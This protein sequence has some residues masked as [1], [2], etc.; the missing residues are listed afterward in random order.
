MS[1]FGQITKKVTTIDK[2]GNKTSNMYDNDGTLKYTY[3]SYTDESGTKVSEQTL[4]DKKGKVKEII[5]SDN[6]GT[7]SASYDEK[8]FKTDESTTCKNGESVTYSY[9]KNGRVTQRKDKSSNG[10]STVTQYD[11]NGNVTTYKEDM[12]YFSGI[13]RY[14]SGEVNENGEFSPDNNGDILRFADGT[15]VNTNDLV[16]CTNNFANID[17]SGINFNEVPVSEEVLPDGNS[18][19]RFSVEK[20]GMEISRVDCYDANGDFT[21]SMLV[22][23][24]ENFERTIPGNFNENGE[25]TPSEDN[26]GTIKVGNNVINVEQLTTYLANTNG[27]KV[28]R[29]DVKGSLLGSVLGNINNI[30]NSL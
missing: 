18:E 16:Q 23:R 30:I 22:Q 7:V 13:T 14:Q 12:D 8:G 21:G 24:G 10:L 27:G 1:M 11:E 28:Q 29:T 25:F 15:E 4:Y 26:K 20:D 6:E 9:D 17:I 3:K 19:R 2:N 5:I